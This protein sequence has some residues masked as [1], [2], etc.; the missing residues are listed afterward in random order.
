M[1]KCIYMLPRVGIKTLGK[2]SPV[3]F[4]LHL[5]TF[6]E[7]QGAGS[8]LSFSQVLLLVTMGRQFFVDVSNSPVHHIVCGLSMHIYVTCYHFPPILGHLTSSVTLVSCPFSF[9][10]FASLA[11][12]LRVSWVAFWFLLHAFGPQPSPRP[13]ITLLL[14]A[15]GVI[16]G[17]WGRGEHSSHFLAS[18][19]RKYPIFCLP[20]E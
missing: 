8:S 1:K 6:V 20:G 10:M 18:W 3:S 7:F 13:R 15:L 4:V 19:E 14:R 2:C 16:R 5:N 17:P 9:W 11:C 12:C